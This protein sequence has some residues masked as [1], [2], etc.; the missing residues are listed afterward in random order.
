MPSIWVPSTSSST[1]SAAL[2]F[3]FPPPAA[4]PGFVLAHP[5]NGLTFFPLEGRAPKSIFTGDIA[6]DEDTEESFAAFFVAERV[7][8]PVSGGVSGTSPRKVALTGV[9]FS[10]RLSCSVSLASASSMSVG[11]SSASR[12]VLERCAFWAAVG[13]RRRGFM[14]E[15][16]RERGRGLDALA[17]ECLSSPEVSSAGN[18]R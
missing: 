7:A 1:T 2:F 9:R 13:K 17:S 11:A 12:S 3:P 4:V 8:C 10:G 15:R 5:S 18:L 14:E 6:G 16:V